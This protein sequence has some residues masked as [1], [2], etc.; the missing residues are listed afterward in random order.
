MG[1]TELIRQFHEQP[2]VFSTVQVLGKLT[3]DLRVIGD[4]VQSPF[5]PCSHLVEPVKEA[6]FLS[7]PFFPARAVRRYSANLSRHWDAFNHH[8]SELFF[9]YR[10]MPS[11]EVVRV[12]QKLPKPSQKR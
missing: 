8:V 11:D 3:F 9:E 12:I 5:F 2:D 7:R 6:V 4:V 1:D 10:S